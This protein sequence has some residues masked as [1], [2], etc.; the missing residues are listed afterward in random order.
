MQKIDK[1]NHENIFNAVDWSERGVEIHSKVS[2]VII[3]CA[4][5]NQLNTCDHL[6]S[7]IQGDPL[8]VHSKHI[9]MQLLS[10]IL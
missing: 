3:K 5:Q 6:H 7:N 1:M 2:Q 4:I 8:R 10:R 9:R